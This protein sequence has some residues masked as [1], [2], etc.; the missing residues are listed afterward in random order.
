MDPTRN[1]EFASNFV[2]ISE[3]RATET[4]TMITQAL[5]EES[6][7][8]TWKVQTGRDR[9]RRY[10]EEQSASIISAEDRS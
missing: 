4:V 2:Q 6:M 3:K 10:S 9:K 5:G 8:R 1:S 7:S